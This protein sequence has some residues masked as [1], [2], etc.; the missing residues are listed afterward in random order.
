MDG[1]KAITSSQLSARSHQLSPMSRDRIN[2][3]ELTI[4]EADIN[5]ELKAES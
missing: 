5:L 4:V 2:A 1:V 3:N